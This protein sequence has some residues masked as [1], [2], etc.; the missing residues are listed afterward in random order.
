MS[1]CPPVCVC[2][3]FRQLGSNVTLNIGTFKS[4]LLVNGAS[5]D[6]PEKYCSNPVFSFP[7]GN[8]LIFGIS[9]FISCAFILPMEINVINMAMVIFF[10]FIFVFLILFILQNYLRYSIAFVYQLLISVTKLLILQSIES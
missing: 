2:Q 1:I 3:L 7:V 8:S 5:Q 9:V 10:I 6:F 4:L